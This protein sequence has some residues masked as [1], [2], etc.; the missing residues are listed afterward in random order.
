MIN[1]ENIKCEYLEP[2][3]VG[4]ENIIKFKDNI[5]ITGADDRYKLWEIPETQNTPQ[6]NIYAI[7]DAD[8][9]DYKIEKLQ[10]KN[11]PKNINF[12]PHGL[13]I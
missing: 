6:G 5:L 3:M 2:F 11:F 4:P 9:K 8:K 13:Y 1:T 7:Y 10:L 12:H